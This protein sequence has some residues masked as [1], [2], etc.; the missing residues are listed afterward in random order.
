MNKLLLA[1]LLSIAT[2]AATSSM[3]NTL[4]TDNDIGGSIVPG[5][6]PC[7][8][9]SVKF[10]LKLAHDNVN[11]NEFTAS[12]YEDYRGPNLFGGGVS[13]FH[14]D[15]ISIPY[16]IS[17]TVFDFSV[18]TNGSGDIVDG[19]MS[20]SGII[21]NNPFQELMSADIIHG[22]YDVVYKQVGNLIGFNTEHILC[23]SVIENLIGGTGC[24]TNEVVYF[25]LDGNKIFDRSKNQNF[26]GTAFTSVPVPAAVWLFGSGL[27]GLVGIARRRKA[28]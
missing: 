21:N 16:S 7:F 28:V 24:T 11:T 8:E 17:D 5:S 18:T 15:G 6:Y 26:K 1:V 2:F 3:A 9:T 12:Y 22:S 27:L 19:S 13:L 4:C 14:L 25:A 23:S 20:I 10:S